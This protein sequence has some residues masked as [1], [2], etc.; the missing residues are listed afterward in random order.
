[1]MAIFS[2]FRT[3]LF[4][5]FIL[6][7]IHSCQE[8]QKTTWD[9]L[10]VSTVAVLEN[11][12]IQ[13]LKNQPLVFTPVARLS[14]F[15]SLKTDCTVAWVKV[16]KDRTSEVIITAATPGL[17]SRI[18]ASVQPE[19]KLRKLNGYEFW[20]IG[21]KDDTFWVLEVDNQLAISTSSLAIEAV[22]RTLTQPA[23]KHALAQL[24]KLPNRR[25]DQGNL[26]VDWSA[27][28][29]DWP[30]ASRSILD[31]QHSASTLMLDG[32]TLLDTARFSGQLLKSMER[33][34]PTTVTLQDIV[35]DGAQ[36][37]LHLGVSDAAAWY[38]VRM[39]QL[40]TDKPVIFDSLQ[41]Q[42]KTTGFSGDRFFSSIDREIGFIR[43][44]HGQVIVCKLK[45]VTKAVNEFKKI[46]AQGN[47]DESNLNFSEHG[48]FM[49]LL[50]WPFAPGF[51]DL[52]YA[53][54]ADLII[55]ANTQAALQLVLE[56]MALDQTWGKT[57][58]WK[59]FHTAMLQE[60]NVSYFFAQAASEKT[61]GVFFAAEVARGYAQFS[62]V[63]QQFYTSI[64]LQFK[65]REA[66]TSVSATPAAS[67]QVTLNQAIQTKPYPVVN[68]TTKAQ[69]VVFIDASGQLNLQSQ[70]K[71]LW[72]LPVGT[73][74]SDIYQIDY[75][76][77]RKLQYAFV[78]GQRL[79]IVDR[80]GRAV[81]GFPI[82]LPKGTIRAMTIVDYDQTRNY[83]FLVTYAN[84]DALLFDG[85]GKTLEGWNPKTFGEDLLNIRFQRMKGKDYFVAQGRRKIFLTNRKGEVLPGFPWSSPE[86]LATG[87]AADTRAGSFIVLSRPGK[88]QWIQPD[89]TVAQEKILPKNS[90]EAR[91][92]LL[93]Q[94]DQFFVLR[95]DRGKLA[96]FSEAGELL[97]EVQNPGSNAV[98]PQAIIQKRKPILVLYDPE[99][100]LV[101][102]FSSTGA[103]ALARPL[104]A[105]TEPGVSLNSEGDIQLFTVN[106]S[107]L[108]T[109]VVR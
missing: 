22:I 56:K 107:Q 53:F 104:E 8:R 4:C 21:S 74:A 82:P 24:K 49:Q 10:P 85:K 44:D 40:Q 88:L 2:S 68:H 63:D 25:Q 7:L 39:A 37:F 87:I 102:V 27:I 34:T 79:H 81:N 9:L 72:S 95:L 71:T 83:R 38:E 16:E 86:D 41:A 109:T 98:L 35:P 80:L 105:S 76:K 96:V 36:S 31:V 19:P 29:M 28:P 45:E 50:F 47:E 62:N 103:P 51:T 64:L 99:Q 12:P 11:T 73:P 20:Q 70:D 59:K 18:K 108:T 78:A 48:Q 14:T 92:H 1:M 54:E 75:F 15:D 46:R 55:M 60:A 6:V 67:N 57:L 65:P 43:T 97:F 93:A 106:G 17:L 58:A 30:L 90:V 23:Q 61:N 77:N 84:G 52:H 101:H 91:F 13:D 32:F 89:G 26:Y 33:Q 42:F 5:L 100:Q 94:P 3:A 69:E 66:N